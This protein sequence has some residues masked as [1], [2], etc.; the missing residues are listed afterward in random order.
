MKKGSKRY[1]LQKENETWWRMRLG[2]TNYS[3]ASMFAEI[4][5]TL[6]ISLNIKLNNKK[7]PMLM[8]LVMQLSVSQ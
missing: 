7:M 4:W 8:S 2:S 3:V 1:P 5:T 6:I